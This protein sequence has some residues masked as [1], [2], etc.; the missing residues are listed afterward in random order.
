MVNAFTKRKLT[1]ESD[2]LPAISGVAKEIQL[3]TGDE[4]LAGLW[5]QDL[6]HELL[7][8]VDYLFAAK[9]STWH[10]PAKYRAPSWS[11]AAIEGPICMDLRPS[12]LDKAHGDVLATADDVRVLEAKIEPI[13]Q[14]PYGEVSG[15][16]LRLSTR[17]WKVVLRPFQN[18]K[19]INPKYWLRPDKWGDSRVMHRRRQVHTPEGKSIGECVLDIPDERDWD[20]TELWWV[21]I[22]VR[23]SGVLVMK[24][25][26]GNAFARVGM[27]WGLDE[28]YVPETEI[29]DILLV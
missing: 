20:A 8:K 19:S 15:G 2:R 1:H 21:K 14:N 9:D 18:S 26:K 13:W 4:Y 23:G 10:R 25:C 12:E 3:Q 16:Y 7:W 24:D 28:S 27:V 17:L 29:A 22:D 6:S 5:R 11:W